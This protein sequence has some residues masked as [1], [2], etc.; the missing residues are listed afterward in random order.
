MQLSLIFLFSRFSEHALRWAR[1][2]RLPFWSISIRRSADRTVIVESITADKQGRLYLPDRVTGNILRVDPKAPKPVVV[3][4]IEITRKSKARRSTPTLPV[5]PLINRAICS[6][7][8][9]HSVRLCASEDADINPQKPGVAETFATGTS[10][11]NGIAFDSSG[12]L[13]V[14]G[15]GSGID[16]SGRPGWWRGSSRGPNGTA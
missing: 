10:G 5:L 3:G 15:G 2:R 16:L 14:S 11:A 6:S 13:F 8:W 12:N 7:L 9:V 4:R 1:P